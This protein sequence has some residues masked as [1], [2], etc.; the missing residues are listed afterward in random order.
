MDSVERA[1]LTAYMN[2]VSKRLA[3]IDAT[4]ASKSSK[5]ESA[6]N[7]W[8]EIAKIALGSWPAFGLLLML[9]FYVPLRDAINT[10]PAKVKTADEI[11]VM[12]ISLKNS[13]QVEA[14]RAGLSQLSELLPELSPEAIEFLLRGSSDNIN[15]LIGYQPWPENPKLID[16]IF[17]PSVRTMKT[18]KELQDKKLISITSP[19]SH[20]G[21]AVSPNFG[22]VVSDLIRRYSAKVSESPTPGRPE[23]IFLRMAKPTDAKLP[24]V[25]WERT[26]LGSKAINI[27]VKS[28]SAQ[29]RN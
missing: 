2:L 19:K 26:E 3:D 6:H 29:L 18:L 28:I 24:I 17:V 15:Q 10:I 14:E 13:F 25:Y 8:L 27:V 1:S 12:G 4:L 21:G 7:T 5:T 16:G 23:L 11:G 9:L 20:N 22:E